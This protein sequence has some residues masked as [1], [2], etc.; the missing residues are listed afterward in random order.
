MTKKEAEKKTQQQ[1]PIMLSFISQYVKDLSFEAP[2]MPGITAELAKKPPEIKVGV[3]VA[4]QKQTDDTFTVNLHFKIEAK[5]GDK[6][7]F[8][9][10]LDYGSLVQIQVEKEHLEPVL[11][12]EVPRH[13][14]PFARGIIATVTREGGFPPLM[15]NPI[16][17]VALYQQR[18]QQQKAN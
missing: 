7:A 10:E 15:L 17:F 14:F 5:T 18:M 1:P 13:L 9:C 8:I 3:D 6:T 12:I 4:A 11:L 2:N 16:D